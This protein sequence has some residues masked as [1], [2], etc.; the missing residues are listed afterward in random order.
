MPERRNHGNALIGCYFT[1]L[2]WAALALIIAVYRWM[3]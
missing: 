3:L 2:L 1:L